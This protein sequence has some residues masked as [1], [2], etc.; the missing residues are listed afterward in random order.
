MKTRGDT[1]LRAARALGALPGDL[2]R[3]CLLH[4][5]LSLLLL[6]VSVGS[7]Q[8]TIYRANGTKQSARVV[9]L[10]ERQ[11]RL[12]VILVPGQSPATITVPRTEVAQVDFAESEEE[13]RLLKAGSE[14]D[15]ASIARWWKAR[16]PFLG[17]PNSN[18]G[19]FGL[20]FA[21]Q[22]LKGAGHGAEALALFEHLEKADWNEA[23]RDAAGRGK[24]VALI[25]VGRAAEAV[26]QAKHLAINAE[27]PA[28]LIEAKYVLAQGA[29]QELRK[30][31]EDN[32]RWEEDDNVR[33]ERHRLYHET[34]DYFL[35]PF[36]FYGAEQ[37]PAARGLAG[38]MEFFVFVKEPVRAVEIARDLT[39]LY[40]GTSE[41]KAAAQFLTAHPPTT[42]A[43]R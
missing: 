27:D 43:A 29:F 42:S 7:G 12:E 34:I 31:L 40:P 24:L 23:R 6:L 14:A 5:I 30:L 25:A 15:P 26:E 19:A 39:V 28:T 36:L 33:P 35:Y 8:D 9:G 21:Q 10:D 41:A 38:A 4:A 32:P 1:E 16:E 20:A 37:A 22:L 3:R 17:F 2:Q 13:R 18:A 11:I